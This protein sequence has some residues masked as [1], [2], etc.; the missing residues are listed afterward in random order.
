MAAGPLVDSPAWSVTSAVQRSAPVE[1]STANTEPPPD[2]A[3]RVPPETTGVP[4]KSPL[5]DLTLQT[6][7]SDES[8]FHD[9]PHCPPSREFARSW[10]YSGQSPPVSGA[11]L[12]CG[13]RSSGLGGSLGF[14]GGGGAGAPPVPTSIA[15]RIHGCSEHT[16]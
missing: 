9:G 3:T 8:S 4:V 6:G 14:G 15:P 10:P 5:V 12:A 11:G 7:R 1:A 2:A 16:N 13:M